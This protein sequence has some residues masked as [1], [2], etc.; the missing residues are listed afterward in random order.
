MQIFFWLLTPSTELRNP[1]YSCIAHSTTT[2]LL[3]S[4]LSATVASTALLD[5][6]Y[7]NIKSG[8][9]N[10]T[11]DLYTA[12][13]AIAHTVESLLH[14]VTAPTGAGTFSDTTDIPQWQAA[15]SDFL[16]ATTAFFASRTALENTSLLLAL[17]TFLFLL[18]RNVAMSGWAQRFGNLGRFSPFTR[19]PTS[20]SGPAKVS[21][22]DFS[23]I[24]A[25]DLRK[26]QAE[27]GRGADPRERAPSPPIDYGPARDTDVVLLRNKRKE[28][29]VHFAA[30]SIAKGELSVGAL[31]DAA[32]KK[33][34]LADAR[35]IKLLYKGKNLKDD[36][37]QCRQEGMRDGSEVMCS[38]ADVSASASESEDDED[39]AD[40][41]DGQPD[42]DGSKKRRNRGKKTKKRNKR[43][44]AQTSGTSTPDAQNLGV[45]PHSGGPS[46]RAQSPRPAGTQTPQT[47]IDKLNAL[48]AK[49]QTYL[50]DCDKFMRNPPSE[51]AKKE[52]EHK[53]L[54]ETILTQV[55]LQLD[56]VETEGDSDARARRKEL[57]KETQ[58][59]LQDLDAVMK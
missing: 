29:A 17:S 3:F 13:I 14:N 46:S 43:E 51:P 57:V 53:K 56:G 8:T 38:V 40:G 44:A 7:N 37:R 22:A 50:P 55:L 42:G 26:H 5:S 59:V 23:Y 16:T 20:A 41:M 34:G 25:D 15:L 21:D 36:D 54:S 24:T 19:S 10:F 48:H 30:Y 49:L 31:R 35:R 1:V 6:V 58:K 12:G 9:G 4:P 28:Y 27:A 45:P 11:S 52:F 33:L 47:P 39:T 32:A 2:L 18:V